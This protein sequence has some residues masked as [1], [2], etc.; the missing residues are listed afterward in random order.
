MRRDERRKAES[1]LHL[2]IYLLIHLFNYF[3]MAF[4]I[5]S[6]EEKEKEK[7]GDR[8]DGV[9]ARRRALHVSHLLN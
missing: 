3:I 8:K 6:A 5:V 1:L 4:S 9:V 7:E 2:F